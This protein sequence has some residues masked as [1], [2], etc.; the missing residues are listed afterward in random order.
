MGLK[1][2]T[3]SSCIRWN[4]FLMSSGAGTIYSIW[5]LSYAHF[6]CIDS[7][8]DII[9][10]ACKALFSEKMKQ[11]LCITEKS[12]MPPFQFSEPG[13]YSWSGL[14]LQASF[15]G[16]HPAPHGEGFMILFRMYEMRWFWLEL[17]K[18]KRGAESP[19]IYTPACCQWSF[20]DNEQRQNVGCKMGTVCSV[21]MAKNQ[22]NKLLTLLWAGAAGAVRALKTKAAAEHNSRSESPH[23]GPSFQTLSS[24]SLWPTEMICYNTV[25]TQPLEKDEAS[26][27]SK[28]HGCADK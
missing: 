21:K 22:G 28:I 16:E 20:N 15:Q 17:R 27:V 6:K 11:K 3:S 8:G 7:E 19:F 9:L 24:S 14:E 26:S 1:F 5:Q 10:K 4:R 25:W 18:Q 23:K 13:L 12:D 2:C